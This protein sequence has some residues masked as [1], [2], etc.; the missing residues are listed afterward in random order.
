[1]GGQARVLGEFYGWFDPELRFAVPAVD[2]NMHPRLFA[3]EEKETESAFP[4]YGWTHLLNLTL[5][6][7]VRGT[8]ELLA[9]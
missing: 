6:A 8:A 5:V 1:V 2:V 3:R 7:A 4:E 9:R